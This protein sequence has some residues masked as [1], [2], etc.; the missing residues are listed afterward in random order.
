MSKIITH[1][2]KKLDELTAQFH[3]SQDFNDL[4]VALEFAVEKEIDNCAQLLEAWKNN[5]NHLQTKNAFVRFSK[6][7]PNIWVGYQGANPSTSVENLKI[8]APD[9][10]FLKQVERVRGQIIEA[11]RLFGEKY[12]WFESSRAF[13]ELLPTLFPEEL[14][15]GTVIGQ[16][17]KNLFPEGEWAKEIEQKG[18]QGA[19]YGQSIYKTIW[20]DD[21]TYHL[22][23]EVIVASSLHTLISLVG[24]WAIDQDNKENKYLKIALD[25][26][27]NPDN[28][29][30]L[31]FVENIQIED[32]LVNMAL[33]AP[34]DFIAAW[35]ARYWLVPDEDFQSS[36]VMSQQSFLCLL[37]TFSFGENNHLP[38]ITT[39]AQKVEENSEKSVELYPS[40]AKMFP[41]H[42]KKELHRKYLS[43]ETL[44]YICRKWVEKQFDELDSLN[45][46]LIKNVIKNY[47]TDRRNKYCGI[48]ILDH[49]HATDIYS[50][51]TYCCPGIKF[52]DIDFTILL[53]YGMFDLGDLYLFD[54][55]H[56]DF[57]KGIIEQEELERKQECYLILFEKSIEE[58]LPELANALLSLFL[59]A[60]TMF[61]RGTLF[62]LSKLSPVIQKGLNLPGSLILKHTLKIIIAFLEDLPVEHKKPGVNLTAMSL[63][64][65][66]PGKREIHAISATKKEPTQK[67]IQDIENQLREL[68]GG[69]R[70][71]KLSTESQNYLR[72]AELTWLSTAMYFGAGLKDWSGHIS[73]FCKVLEKEIID[74]LGT[75][76]HSNIYKDYLSRNGKKRPRLPMPGPLL[77]QLNQYHQFPKDLQRL[78]QSS[79]LSIYNNKKLLREIQNLFSDYRNVASHKDPFTMKKYSDFREIYFEKKLLARFIDHLD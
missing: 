45:T 18:T 4:M 27:L 55:D 58:G 32:L 46:S 11:D 16:Y 40:I 7:L 20:L 39:N 25:C 5:V 31:P 1:P 66:F 72:D 65:Y 42:L 49:C 21:S 34:N 76:F 71:D 12:S 2:V 44:S 24:A 74:R 41:I 29:D 28:Y 6:L 63:R 35:F 59:V 22:K 51:L 10:G 36:P 37:L 38:P 17:L 60:L 70:W 77:Y 47:T 26:M 19:F 61:S 67:N 54:A 52:S 8:Q 43:Y 75:M 78:V 23:G 73:G 9:P 56:I 57:E 62:S 30:S 79:G 69:D 15:P 33:F 68:L 13:G 3:K 14:D 50:F 53:S 64:S 48:S